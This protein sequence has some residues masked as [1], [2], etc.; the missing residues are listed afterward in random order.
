MFNVLVTHEEML[1]DDMTIEL[2]KNNRGKEVSFEDM[3][4]CCILSVDEVKKRIVDSIVNTD[5][6]NKDLQ[7]KVEYVQYQSVCEREK[8]GQFTEK[9][10]K[11]KKNFLENENVY[12]LYL[13]CN[14][15]QETADLLGVCRQTL[16]KYIKY[17]EEKYS[18][19]KGYIG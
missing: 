15:M 3:V 17:F 18:N 11:A 1:I 10:A 12:L 6:G 9:N 13:V 2:M 14:N 7:T 4:K 19:V 8:N 5:C 16:A